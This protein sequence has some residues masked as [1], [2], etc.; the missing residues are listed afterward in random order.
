MALVSLGA[1]IA[2][3]VKVKMGHAFASLVHNTPTAVTW[4]L[5]SAIADVLITSSLIYNLYRRKTGLP[6]ADD[7]ISRIIRMTLQ[8]GL[9]TSICAILDLVLIATEVHTTM[10][11]TPEAD[12]H[13]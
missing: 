11:V 4:L 1:G 5:S 9:I 2:I 3:G 7:V 8:T 13:W 6:S 12:R 10:F